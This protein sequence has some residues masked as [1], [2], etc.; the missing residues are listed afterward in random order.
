MV[1]L[2]EFFSKYTSSA[3]YLHFVPAGKP[4]GLVRLASGLPTS[5]LMIPPLILSGSLCFF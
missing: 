5:P 2:D 4:K 3:S 1:I